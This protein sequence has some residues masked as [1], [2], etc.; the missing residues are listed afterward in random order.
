VQL[1]VQTDPKADIASAITELAARFGAEVLAQDIPS[2][3][4]IDVDEKSVLELQ[5]ELLQL[6]GVQSA[7]VAPDVGTA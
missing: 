3:F 6:D 4:T 2:L 1:I 5:A 7:Y